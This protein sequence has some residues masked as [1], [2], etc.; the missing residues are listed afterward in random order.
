MIINS[1]SESSSSVP[2]FVLPGAPVPSP[3]TVSSEALLAAPPASLPRIASAVESSSVGGVF[4]V[5]KSSSALE[6]SATF[7][8]DVPWNKLST[9]SVILN[10]VDPPGTSA[11]APVLAVAVVPLKVQSL[12]AG[13][14]VSKVNP[15]G[16]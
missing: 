4:P 15:V 3:F 8:I 10:V 2:A 1:G 7:V 6:I 5:F 9:V 16:I 12:F 13:S 11:V 14:V